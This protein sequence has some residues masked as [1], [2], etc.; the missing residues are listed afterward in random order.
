[1][2]KLKRVEYKRSD[3]KT[4]AIETYSNGAI[5]EVEIRN[6]MVSYILNGN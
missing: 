5:K 1:M 2:N 6:G 4:I 3:G